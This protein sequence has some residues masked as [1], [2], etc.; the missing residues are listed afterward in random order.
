MEFIKENIED[1]NIRL[2]HKGFEIKDDHILD[3]HSVDNDSKIMV[4]KN[5]KN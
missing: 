4:T 2:F 3:Q 5:L 1:Y